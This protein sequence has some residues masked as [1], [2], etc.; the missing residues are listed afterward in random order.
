MALKIQSDTPGQRQLVI[1]DRSPAL[2]GQAGQVADRGPSSKGGRN[3][4]GRIT[5][6]Q[7]RWRSQAHLPHGRFQASQARTFGTVE[8]MEYDPNRTAFIALITYADGDLSYIL[9]PQ[10][11]N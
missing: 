5:V 10:R 9:A 8:R 11:L 6:R 7:P 2:E 1:V 3:N 4:T